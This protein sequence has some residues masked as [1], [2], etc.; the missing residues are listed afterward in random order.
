MRYMC[1]ETTNFV[2]AC[3]ALHAR[4]ADGGTLTPDERDLIGFSGSG[5][6]NK[7]RPMSEV[8]APIVGR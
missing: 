1:E 3:D 6:L 8:Y 7:L 4:L 2:H 5:L